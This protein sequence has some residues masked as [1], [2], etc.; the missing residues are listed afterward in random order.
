MCDRKP[1]ISIRV[2]G[3]LFHNVK[4]TVYNTVYENKH[5]YRVLLRYVRFNNVTETI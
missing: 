2:S 4:Y 1:Y 3:S 5:S